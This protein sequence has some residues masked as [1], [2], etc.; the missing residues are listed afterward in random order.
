[1]EKDSLFTGIVVGI[2][3]PVIAYFLLESVFDYLNQIGYLGE[4][5]GEGFMRRVRTIGI[6]AICANIIPFEI[7]RKNRY[8][9][10]L[11]GLVFP[12]LIYVGAW[13]Y[14]YY[15]ILFA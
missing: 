5:V 8:D 15:Y 12:T 11:R 4:A 1:M 2:L 9:D 3:L 7:A 14:K 6:I 10:T 13:I